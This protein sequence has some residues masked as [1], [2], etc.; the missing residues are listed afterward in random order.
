M[1]FTMPTNASRGQGSGSSHSG[2]SYTWTNSRSARFCSETVPENLAFPHTPGGYGSE[3]IQISK[4]A[5]IRPVMP[6]HDFGHKEEP[7]AGGP[8]ASSQIA[9][10]GGLQERLDSAYQVNRFSLE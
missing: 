2:D 4:G 9:V 10:L 3:I 8:E 6:G 5:R 7:P 1:R